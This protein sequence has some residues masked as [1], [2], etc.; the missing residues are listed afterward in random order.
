MSDYNEIVLKLPK[1]PS[2]NA[3]YA[4]KH[5]TSRA[6]KKNSYF[7]HI[8]SELDKIDGWTMERFSVDITYNC[9]Y[10]VDN[11]IVCT[12][13]LVDYLRQN[14]YVADDTPK[15]FTAQKTQYDPSLE[16]DCF[17]AK[18]KCYGYKTRGDDTGAVELDVLQGSR[19]NARAGNKAVRR[20]TRPKRKS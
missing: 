13:F 1:P 10:D 17:V 16:K 2:L 11:A 7:K 19:Q 20:A 9:R 4:G 3:F 5:W 14:G 15:F 6:S 12:K 8:K 18:I